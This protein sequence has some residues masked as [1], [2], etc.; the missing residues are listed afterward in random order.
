MASISSKKLLP[1][2]EKKEKVFLVPY[3]NIVPSTPKLGGVKPAE[4]KEE[5][6]KTSEVNEKLSEVVKFFR[7]SLLLKERDKRR[8]RREQERKRFEESES[9]LETKKL[10]KKR[11]QEK[12]A[13]KIP[14]STIFDKLA[15]FTGFTLLGFVFNNFSN[16][17][18]ALNS[19]GSFLAPAA[20][21]IGYFVE[22]LFSNTLEWID[23]G[24]KAYDAVGKIVKDLGGENYER[25]FNEFSSTL[26]LVINGALLA[27]AAGLRGGLFK[28]QKTPVQQIRENVGGGSATAAS[29][30]SRYTFRT[31]KD[32]APIGSA[33]VSNAM[34]RTS[35]GLPS[36]K[37]LPTKVA[38]RDP[39][40]AL[41]YR[42][43][44]PSYTSARDKAIAKSIVD[45][46]TNQTSQALRKAG[47][48]V[49]DDAA[50]RNT[51]RNVLRAIGFGDTVGP[52]EPL[53]PS[54]RKSSTAP[55]SK[56]DYFG[57]KPKVARSKGPKVPSTP[58][59][60]LTTS[61][62]LGQAI[63]GDISRLQ[64]SYKKLG[65]SNTDL[66]SIVKDIDGQSFNERQAAFE[67]LK[68]KGLAYTIEP[69]FVPTLERITTPEQREQ[70][71][72]N[73]RDLKLQER[74][75]RRERMT[76]MIRGQSFEAPSVPKPGQGVLPKPVIPKV[77]P[78]GIGRAFGRIPIVGPLIDFTISL[79]MGDPIGKAAAGAVGAAVG[80]AIGGALVGSG[81]F[82]LGAFLGAAVGGFIG[83]LIARSL[84][85]AVAAMSGTREKYNQ[86]G[87]VASRQIKSETKP[88][89]DTIK[90]VSP[91]GLQSRF[92]EKDLKTLY[93]D[94]VGI[95]AK[96]SGIMSSPGGFI[97]SLMSSSINLLFGQ[98]FDDRLLSYIRQTFGRGVESNVRSTVDTV[99]RNLELYLASNQKTKKKSDEEQESDKNLLDKIVEFFRGGGKTDPPPA[100]SDSP[101][102]DKTF[103]N[104]KG[105]RLK[106]IRR[107]RGDEDTT[108][109]PSADDPYVFPDGTILKPGME[110]GSLQMTP[111]YA[112]HMEFTYAIQPVMV[113]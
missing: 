7:Y 44:K 103:L 60:P 52:N 26:N 27:G 55:S 31:I 75:R 83:D 24:Y 1:S 17:L 95:L 37:K 84:Y 113:G 66:K 11:Q 33:R 104:M 96:I 102:V 74:L 30:F 35:M 39:K 49:I 50:N 112:K 41:G 80:S 92:S 77:R 57:A 62:A 64:K 70:I 72:R 63:S 108:D 20:K 68:K 54:K 42:P 29:G 13:A 4:G 81:T 5:T 14:G 98:K 101:P 15:R 111:T 69:E 61:E 2:T 3:T 28:P 22:G 89:E 38:L 21:G 65:F 12:L 10:G 110:V 32:T 78:R 16:L 43:Q 107:T 46:A 47:V 76:S 82:G 91:V 34:L 90:T 73:K 8:K 40:F 99:V 87:V 56:P 79:L 45:G 25:L 85:D 23:K 58:P 19:I 88:K 53:R 67:I 51:A 94:S 105:G 9:K 48:G 59:R 18:P 97:G 36:A 93:G 100:D 6:A 109:A 106:N 71:K 86:G